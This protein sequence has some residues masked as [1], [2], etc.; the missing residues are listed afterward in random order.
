LAATFTNRPLNAIERSFYY[1]GLSGVN[2]QFSNWKFNAIAPY[3]HHFN[4]SFTNV[5]DIDTLGTASVIGD[6][7][8]LTTGG[9]E[10]GV[11]MYPSQIYAHIGF[12]STIVW[13]PTNCDETYNGADG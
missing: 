4:F 11:G 5:S 3:K 2:G 9:S 7:L 13:T 1:M 12:N 6:S 8:R 10:A